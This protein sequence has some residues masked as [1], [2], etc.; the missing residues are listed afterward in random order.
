VSVKKEYPFIV[1]GGG[2]GGLAAAL[3][4]VETGQKVCVIER[5]PEFGEIGAGLQLG[6]NALAALDQLGVLGAVKEKAVFPR[7]LVLLD[8]KTGEELSSLD[9]GEKFQQRYGYPYMVTHRSDLHLALLEACQ[10]KSE[11]TLLNDQEVE[12]IE[13][14]SDGI[15]IHC[16]NGITYVAEAA[17]G[18]DGIKS[19]SRN[20][21]SDDELVCSEYVAYRGTIPTSQV[22][23]PSHF[24]DVV[25]Y[26]GPDHHLVQYPVRNKELYNQV[27]VFKSYNYKEGTEDWGT[28]EELKK[29]FSDCC[30]Q[31][32]K[33]VD[34]Y[35]ETNR[36]WPLY[37]RNPINNWTEGNFTL[38]GDAAHPMLQ[39]LAQGACQALEDSIT[40]RDKLR[41]NSEFNKAFIAYQEERIPRASKVQIRARTFG[42]IIHTGDPTAI[43]LRNSLLEQR[44]SD[45]FDIADWIYGHQISK[46]LV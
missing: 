17:V 16:T 25:C 30:P 34:N 12:S 11:I 7:R 5:A 9:L 27:A 20:L 22:S 31:V 39:F 26:T 38:L 6:P 14:N 24:E 37:D 28:K 23:K 32:K 21:F 4:V 46:N 19:V 8:S 43:L 35:I 41:E 15:K 13:N 18:A 36:R 33:A 44:D 29:R 2:I 40:L 1:I 10:S 42:D 3:A 45:N